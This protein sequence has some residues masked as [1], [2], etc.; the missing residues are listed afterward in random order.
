MESKN[1]RATI[2][3]LTPS[4]E[5]QDVFS[6][7]PLAQFEHS[8][9][10]AEM[11]EVAF[12][13][14]SLDKNLLLMIWTFFERREKLRTRLV[15]KYL[16]MI[17]S[18]SI[19]YPPLG[20]CGQDVWASFSIEISRAFP[21]FHS[22]FNIL[23]RNMFSHILQSLE[24]RSSKVRL[25]DLTNYEGLWPEDLLD[26]L[27]NLSKIHLARVSNVEAAWL[28]RH[29]KEITG[30]RVSE[31]TIELVSVIPW[32]WNLES[33]GLPSDP[34]SAL[35]VPH[36][37]ESPLTNSLLVCV[38]Q[39]CLKLKRIS[40]IDRRGRL[41]L[42]ENT[43]AMLFTHC[44]EL[45]VF[46]CFGL[47]RSKA[48]LN[49]VADF[50]N[51]Q[52]L[53]TPN[54]EVMCSLIERGYR[55]SKLQLSAKDILMPWMID[56]LETTC[57][58]SITEIVVCLSPEN[59]SVFRTIAQIFGTRV[60]SL[61][62]TL[63]SNLTRAAFLSSVAPHF[64]KFS[65]L[66]YL[67]LSSV[68]TM[69][70]IDKLINLTELTIDLGSVDSS[71]QL[72]LHLGRTLCVLGTLYVRRLHVSFVNQIRAVL[73]ESRLFPRLLKL[74]VAPCRENHY[75]PRRN[76][77]HVALNTLDGDLID[78]LVVDLKDCVLHGAANRPGLFV[79]VV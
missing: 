48:F 59:V 69:E 21:E 72:L 42:T 50:P 78:R 75:W 16:A 11:V 74:I 49:S 15:C 45:K 30:V 70:S 79:E 58:L 61:K 31:V 40:T 63:H 37:H 41:S 22:L 5:M 43:L 17:G 27:P 18:S 9:A 14:L 52:I 33:I 62:C 28:R 64:L 51:L 36:P 20:H 65:A 7:L 23:S 32:L 60:R 38:A 6:E 3:H 57:K 76:D 68:M 46:N 53:G 2:N 8:V 71:G 12:P 10:G 47:A 67:A 1:K 24:G 34:L 73:C 55:P 25:V 54:L 77:E 4:T 29:G 44:H 19:C 39:H 26:Q 13:L 56:L 66:K 35:F